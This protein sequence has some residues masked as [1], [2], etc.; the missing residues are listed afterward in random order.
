MVFIS[1][2]LIKKIEL[3][4]QIQQKK[5]AKNVNLRK[6]LVHLVFYNATCFRD[7]FIKTIA[8]MIRL[9]DAI[10]TMATLQ[11]NLGFCF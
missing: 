8:F 6:G 2:K 9:L 1:K 7:H 11:V 4:I 10:N 3:L 5:Q